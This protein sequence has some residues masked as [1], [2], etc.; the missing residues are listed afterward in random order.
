MPAARAPMCVEML[1]AIAIFAN[2]V[3]TNRG[4]DLPIHRCGTTKLNIFMIKVY[5]GI[6]LVMMYFPSSAQIE[7]TDYFSSG[8]IRARGLTDSAGNKL[9]EW[10]SFYPSGIKS[11]VE[12]FDQGMLNGLVIY[13]YPNEVVQGRET[14]KLGQLQDSAWYFHPSGALHR[15][16]QYS[17]SRYVNTWTHYFENGTIERIVNYKDGLPDGLTMVYNPEGILIQEGAYIKGLENGSWK[18]YD[19]SG[20]LQYVGQYDNGKPVGIWY[21]FVRGKQKVYKRY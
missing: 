14:W 1:W 17:H 5:V 20:V 7:K 16:G 13:Y 9:G 19:S 10:L 8:E 2:M 18:F 12:H 3:N 15:K 11:A 6:Y 4:S 21:E